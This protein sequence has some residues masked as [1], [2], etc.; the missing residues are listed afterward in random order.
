MLL[1]SPVDLMAY[2]ILPSSMPRISTILVILV[3]LISGTGMMYG[4]S[5]W[6]S[7]HDFQLKQ[8]ISEKWDVLHRYMI[9]KNKDSGYISAGSGDLTLQ[10]NLTN[11]LYLRAGFRLVK[12]R[13]GGGWRTEDRPL[14]ALGHSTTV[15]GIKISNRS[16]I[17]FRKYHFKEDGVRYRHKISIELPWAFTQLELKPYL[18]EELFYSFDLGDFQSNWLTF[19]LSFKPTNHLKVKLGHRWISQKSGNGW[20]YRH[21]ICTAMGFTY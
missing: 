16:R 20:T 4:G 1:Y 6:G 17:E 14:F 18:E 8:N 2:L 21:Q 11:S 19:G 15:N 9:S 7:R 10:Y 12:S 3:T 13:R 5:D